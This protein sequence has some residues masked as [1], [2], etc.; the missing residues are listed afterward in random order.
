MSDVTSESNTAWLTDLRILR[1][2]RRA[3]GFDSSSMQKKSVIRTKPGK[4]L[5]FWTVI[6]EKWLK[7]GKVWDSL[8][9]GTVTSV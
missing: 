3:A 5:E 8:Q 6:R 7:M 4:V 1:S 9:C 2:R